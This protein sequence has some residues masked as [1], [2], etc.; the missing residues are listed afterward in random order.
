MSTISITRKA[1]IRPSTRVTLKELAFCLPWIL[2]LLSFYIYPMATSFYWTF[3]DYR[4]LNPPRWIG[5]QNYT[6]M[7]K[8]E[9]VIKSLQNTFVYVAM[10]LPA[11]MVVALAL[12]LLLNTNVRGMTF[13][14]SLYYFPVLVPAVASAI[15]WKWMLDPQWGIVNAMLRAASTRSSGMPMKNWRRRKM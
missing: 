6:L 3:T 13:Y 12:A 8:D 11:S 5:L 10:W 4:I 7:F 14:R 15:V 2:G 9:V 1:S